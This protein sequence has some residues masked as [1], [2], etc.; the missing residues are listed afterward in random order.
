MRP[1]VLLACGEPMRGDDALAFAVL[2]ALPANTLAMADVRRVRQLMPEDLHDFVG[3]VIV[4]DAVDGPTPGTLVDIPLS[5][6]RQA[7]DEGLNPASSHALPL[8][9]TLGI[10]ERLAGGLPEGR[11][12]GVAASDYSLGAALSPAVTDAVADCAA[13]VNHWVRAL[14]HPSRPRACA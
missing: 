7:Y 12:I 2:D 14:A 6:L 8:P 10:V 4:L 1:V 5:T 3:P 11:F 9:I 13:R